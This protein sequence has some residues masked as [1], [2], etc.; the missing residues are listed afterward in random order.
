MAEEQ[1]TV[2]SMRI[3]TQM[4]DGTPVVLRVITPNDGDL[5]RDGISKLSGE[6]RY[7]RFFSPAPT[8]PDSVVDKLIDVDGINHLAWGAI[9]EQGD[10]PFAVGAVHAVRHQSTSKA[11]EYA[12]TVVDKFHGQGIARMLTAALLIDCREAGL[13]ELDVHILSENRAA[14]ALVRSMG[15]VHSDTDAGVTDYK[16]QVEQAISALKTDH[17]AK[18]L[19]A[20]FQ[21]L[22]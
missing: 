21:Q 17:S 22:E 1:R 5:L 20:V 8:I 4:N 12:V 10:Q 16:L 3:H 2:D 15:A 18:G 6:S 13:T 9:C 14:A 7:L 19:Q 11:G